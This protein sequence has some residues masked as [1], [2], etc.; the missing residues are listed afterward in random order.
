MW[1]ILRGLGAANKEQFLGGW[2]GGVYSDVPYVL[3]F[4]CM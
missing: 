4:Y 2:G 3:R 1:E